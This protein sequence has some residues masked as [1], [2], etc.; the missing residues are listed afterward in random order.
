[1]DLERDPPNFFS[2][3]YIDRRSEARETGTWLEEARRDP[4]TLYVVSRG[5]AQLLSEIGV[6]ERA[7][8]IALLAGEHPLLA[9][10]PDAHLVLLGWF[11]GT[12]CILFEAGT[13]A[14]LEAPP[15]MRFE[16]LRPL[17]ARLAPEEAGLLAYARALSIWRAR[18]RFCGVCGS[19]TRPER[20]GHLLRCTASTCAQEFFPR[21]DPAIIVLVS[22][23]E[24]ALLG[25]QPSWP[26][27]RYSTIAGFVE[28][29]ESLEDAV[30]REVRE[31]TGVEVMRVDYHSSQPWPFPSSL[32]LGFRALAAPGAAVH[33]TGELEEARWFT[34]EE[35][36]SGTPTLPPAH[37]ISFRLIASWFDERSAVPLA[38]LR[39]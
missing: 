3:P 6:D 12:R 2:G 38:A 28:P 1:M 32:M 17:S 24:R 20:A 30:A 16:E 36:A 7:P 21:I 23:G 27:G 22:D 4:R 33:V 13:D 15:G 5:T 31:E 26:P 11:R 14:A 25:R 19:P 9:S 29:G 10:A 34:R 35:I 8:R 39:T 37:A 18:H